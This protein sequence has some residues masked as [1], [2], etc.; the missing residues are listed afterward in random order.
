[1]IFVTVGTTEFDDLVNAMDELAPQLKKPVIIQVGHGHARPRHA[2]K[3][4]DFAPSLDEYMRTAELIVSHG[5]LGSLT[6]AIR[7]RRRVV[8]ISNHN[9]YDLHQ[10]EILKHFESQKF[11]IW[12]RSLDQLGAAIASAFEIEFVPY[13]EAE[14]TLNEVIHRRI[15]HPGLTRRRR[16]FNLEHISHTIQR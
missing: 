8:G 5:G 11:L 7:A 6:E 9:R 14:C 10:D 2:A 15:D 4:F 3:W 12:C 1:M 13:A 16:W